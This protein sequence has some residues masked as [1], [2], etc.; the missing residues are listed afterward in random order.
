MYD[1]FDVEHFR[2]FR[3]MFYNIALNIPRAAPFTY[4][5][6]DGIA[7]GSRVLVPLGKRVVTGTVVEADAAP[8]SAAKAIIEVLDEE[9][10]FTPALLRFTKWMAD[11]Y[12]CSW[13][14]VLDAALPTGLTPTS[15]FYAKVTAS[16]TDDDLTAMERRAPKRTE[17]LAYLRDTSGPLRLDG[18]PST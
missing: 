18:F 14:E 16:V 4:S 7:V 9:P 6:E 13:G 12:L 17:L 8:L 2:N 1:I 10:A 15:M 5:G 11:Y 3:E